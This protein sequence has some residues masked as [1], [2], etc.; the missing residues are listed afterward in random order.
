M[1]R[2]MVQLSKEASG[3]K[4]SYIRK[5]CEEALEYLRSAEVRTDVPRHQIRALCLTALQLSLESRSTKLTHLAITGFQKLLDDPI[6]EAQRTT[7]A[8]ELQADWLPMQVMRAVSPTHS[9]PEDVQTDVLK[10]LLNIVCSTAWGGVAVVV[11]R[12]VDVCIDSFANSSQA[13][14]KTV[15]KATVYQTVASFCQREAESRAAARDAGEAAAEQ[16]ADAAGSGGGSGRGGGRGAGFEGAIEVLTFFC[17]KLGYARGSG[18]LNAYVPLLLEGVL[19][20][21]SN[22]PRDIQACDDFINLLLSSPE[23]LVDLA[24]PVDNDIHSM[25]KTPY[26]D[27]ALLKLI[28]DSLMECSHCSDMAVCVAS[29]QC[30]DSLLTSVEKLSEGVG[31]NESQVNWIL[32]K[33]AKLEE[34]KGQ[35]NEVDRISDTSRKDAEMLPDGSHKP[36]ADDL[37]HHGDVPVG[38]DVGHGENPKEA[39]DDDREPC[40]REPDPDPEPAAADAEAS[41]DAGDTDSTVE[42]QDHEANRDLKR[43]PAPETSDAAN[44]PTDGASVASLTSVVGMKKK[45]RREYSDIKDNL[46]K[47]GAKEREWIENFSETRNQFSEMERSNARDFSCRL[48]ELLPRLLRIRSS[49]EVDDAL[50][51]FASSY[52]EELAQKQKSINTRDANSLSHIAIVNADGVYLACYSAL[53]FN[54]K[55]IHCGWY[56]DS[57]SNIPVSQ[58]QFIDEVHGSG[59]LVYLSATWLVELY[60]QLLA[61]NLLSQAG[62]EEDSPNNSAL[63]N[64]LTETGTLG[65]RT[66]SRSTGYVIVDVDNVGTP[67]QGDQLLSDY[68]RLEKAALHVEVPI[69]VDIGRSETSRPHAVCLLEQCTR[70]AICA[71]EWEKLLRYHGESESTVR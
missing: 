43:E 41:P 49:I 60:Q 3:N 54:L 64:L 68:R 40:A 70:G 22:V 7:T 10:L 27:I 16:D 71:A 44:P 8:D 39:E 18:N 24:G 47:H 32:H 1:E 29:I 21:L 48:A 9:L 61:S 66:R 20:M 35:I 5:A 25:N 23:S 51:Q 14:M 33:Y 45:E 62:Y 55:L 65:C 50:Q 2:L 53:L 12:V 36:V 13:G 42:K 37:N 52:C 26:S 31:L 11:C 56:R 19:A 4:W 34:N 28:T 67:Q 46:D 58:R 15:A 69:S 57:S 30:V 38:D 63:I 6:A 59:V 17:A